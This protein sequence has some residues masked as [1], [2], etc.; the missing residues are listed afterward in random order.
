MNK[1]EEAK[2]NIKLYSLAMEY[3]NKYLQHPK[4]IVRKSA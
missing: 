1:F 4:R 2:Y 3:F